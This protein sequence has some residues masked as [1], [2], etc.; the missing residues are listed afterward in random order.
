MY[1]STKIDDFWLAEKVPYKIAKIILSNDPPIYLLEQDGTYGLI[2]SRGDNIF[3]TY[4]ECQNW[5]NE[6]MK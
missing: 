3:F 4:E 5:S 1:L 2:S 6:R